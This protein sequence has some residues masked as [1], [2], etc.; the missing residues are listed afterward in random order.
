[1]ICAGCS[2]EII[3]ST[4]PLDVAVREAQGVLEDPKGAV[5]HRSCAFEALAR[6][7]GT[8]QVA[9][10]L[11]EPEQVAP[12]LKYRCRGCHYPAAEKFFVGRCPGCGFH[13]DREMNKKVVA[14]SRRLS[15][16]ALAQMTIAKPFSTGIKEVDEVLSGGLHK[17]SCVL[18]GAERGCGKSTILLQI[19]AYIATEKHPVVY[20]S[21]EMGAVGIARYTQ[22][23]GIT[24]EHLVIIP[25]ERGGSD[26]EHVMEEVTEQGRKPKLLVVD[27][28][29][30]VLFQ[31]VDADAG[32][33]SQ[34]NAL[35]NYL[36]DF[37][38][39]KNIA[40]I[41]VGQMTGMGDF[42]GGTRLQH[43][44][45][46]LLVM[47]NMEV[48]DPVSGEMENKGLRQIL[49]ADKSR[50]GRTDI[51]REMLLVDKGFV[52]VRRRKGRIH[53]VERDEGEEEG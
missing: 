41:L 46:T 52:S 34:I 28:T 1:M 37:V 42:H 25:V 27:S 44:V 29:Q 31:G 5:W 33:P 6:M 49:L 39:E 11:D 9:E 14:D 30:T 20:A 38:K 43:L 3:L 22:R 26:I 53:L 12:L 48:K 18:W 13:Y 50:T 24:N 40:T 51:V 35:A 47:R 21:G 16:A 45:D 23:L 19:A 7:S 8:G 10:P 15:A 2:K 4:E 17:D 32:S 36:N